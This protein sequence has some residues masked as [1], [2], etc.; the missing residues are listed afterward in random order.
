MFHFLTGA[1]TLAL[2]VL[3]YRLES[4]VWGNPRT[5]RGRVRTKEQVSSQDRGYDEGRGAGSV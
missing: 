4:R 2:N 5:W 1:D 3:A